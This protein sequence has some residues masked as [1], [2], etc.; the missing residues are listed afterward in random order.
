MP[1]QT[2]RSCRPRC[3][4]GIVPPAQPSHG[5][6]GAEPR[7]FR[8]TVS[9]SYLTPFL[10]F[11]DC[12]AWYRSSIIAEGGVNPMSKTVLAGMSAVAL[13]RFMRG[14]VIATALGLGL[15]LVWAGPASAQ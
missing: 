9:E 1:G 7:P 14:R 4:F 15:M 5:P 3:S 8:R 6:I 12:F 2:S 13:D 11:G 10:E